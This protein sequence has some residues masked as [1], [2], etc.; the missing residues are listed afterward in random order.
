MM[1]QTSTE[2]NVILLTEVTKFLTEVTQEGEAYFV[3]HLR[4][5]VHHDKETMATETVWPDLW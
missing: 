2:D 3:S 5:S 1:M 4:R